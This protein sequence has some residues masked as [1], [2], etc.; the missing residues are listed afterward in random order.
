MRVICAVAELLKYSNSVLFKAKSVQKLSEL[1]PYMDVSI[2]PA[3]E[4]SEASAKQQNG[5][6][7]VNFCFM[8]AC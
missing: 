7:A 1:N 6:V 8:R 4:V 5:I 2:R 3:R